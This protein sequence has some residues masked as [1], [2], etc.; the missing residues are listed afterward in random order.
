MKLFKKRHSKSKRR[1]SLPTTPE[2][3]DPPVERSESYRIRD[4]ILIEEVE[5]GLLGQ[6]QDGSLE[7]ESL[8]GDAAEGDDSNYH[9]TSGSSN[10]D[11]LIHSLGPIEQVLSNE[12]PDSKTESLYSCPESA[13]QVLYEMGWEDTT[14]TSQEEQEGGLIWYAS[15]VPDDFVQ[16]D[17]T[18]KM[19]R[20]NDYDQVKKCIKPRRAGLIVKSGDFFGS[21]VKV[22]PMEE[23]TDCE[24]DFELFK[25]PT[26][27]VFSGV[28]FCVCALPKEF[29]REK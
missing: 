1:Q 6:E 20:P 13:K 22:D 3:P 16:Q 17:G 12:S 19:M 8:D 14:T 21:L 11:A 25:R 18:V 10:N 7:E 28:R 29:Q 23:E 4:G 26:R 15:L 27:W 24:D 9:S 5:Q 2:S